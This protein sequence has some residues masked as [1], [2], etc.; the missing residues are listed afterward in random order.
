MEAAAPPD[1]HMRSNKDRTMTENQHDFLNRR[2]REEREAAI[3]ALNMSAAQAHVEFAIE[4]GRRLRT[5]AGHSRAELR[6]V[7]DE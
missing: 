6:T 5:W 4:Y 2:I 7:L 3:A 1:I